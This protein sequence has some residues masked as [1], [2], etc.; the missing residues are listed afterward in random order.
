MQGDAHFM[1][2]D[3][4]DR[5]IEHDLILRDLVAL[6]LERFG[7]ITCRDRAIELAGVGSL[8]DQLD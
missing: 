8:A 5:T 3:R 2:A 4:L 6:R 1:H 7:E